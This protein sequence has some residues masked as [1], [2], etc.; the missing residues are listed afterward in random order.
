MLLTLLVSCVLLCL[1]CVLVLSASPGGGFSFGRRQLVTLF[2]AETA[3]IL[4]LTPLFSVNMGI[5]HKQ[6]RKLLRSS[7]NPR[8]SS[9]IFVGKWISSLKIV[10]TLCVAPC[11]AALCARALIGGVPTW[12]IV[13][14]SLVVMA[15][16][17]CALL[18]GLYCSIICGDVFSAA[19][20]ALLIVVLVC[21]EPIW[22][23]PAIASTSNASFLIQSSLL[24]NPVVGLAS[25][26][27]FDILRT[28][29]LYQICPIAQRRSHY[30]A[31]YTVVSFDLLVSLFLFWRSSVAIRRMVAPSA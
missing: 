19:G 13:R 17:V 2:M 9:T 12:D 1:A 3:L 16:A 30:P 26:L 22:I 15:V 31:W 18:L 21:T 28:E 6:G 14:T 20:V 24:I 8:E 11:V 4:F 5:W 29:P 7:L 25:A 23:G 27:D 10:T